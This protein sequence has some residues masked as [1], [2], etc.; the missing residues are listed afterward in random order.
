MPPARAV[1]VEYAFAEASYYALN[2]IPTVTCRNGLGHTSVFSEPFINAGPWGFEIRSSEHQV[3]LRARVVPG[4]PEI[5]LEI[6]PVAEVVVGDGTA[7]ARVAYSVSITVPAITLTGTTR[8]AG[9]RLVLAGQ[10]IRATIA[11]PAHLAQP[12]TYE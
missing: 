12:P 1:A 4:G 2:H 7:S 6:D 9:G 8:N 3:G 10:E 5:E 11:D